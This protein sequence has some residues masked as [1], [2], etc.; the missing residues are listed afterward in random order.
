MVKIVALVVPLGLDTFVVG[1]TLGGLTAQRRMRTSPLSKTFDGGMPLIGLGIGRPLG[2]TIGSA[3][4]YLAIAVLFALAIHV[5]TADDDGRDLRSLRAD[6]ARASI[7]L[8]ISISLDELA[9]GFT[10]GLLRVPVMPVIAL[11]AVQTFLVTQAGMRL[12]TTV[13]ERVSEGA[14]RLAGAALAM[15]GLGLLIA[16]LTA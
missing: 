6:G 15:L 12:G 8:G 5:L 1:A 3:A 2:T 9:I 14:E 10:F 7:A 16:K 13:G 11:I 4:D